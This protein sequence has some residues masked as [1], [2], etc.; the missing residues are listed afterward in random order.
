MENFMQSNKKIWVDLGCG[1][2]KPE[3]YIG[4]DIRKFKGVDHVLDLG[5][6]PMPFGD[7]FVD[8]LRALHLFE[9]FYP[10]ELFYCIEECWR[11]LKPKGRIHIEVPKA[12]TMAYYMHPDHKIQFVENTFSFFQ[13]PAGGIDPHGY[14]KHFWHVSVLESPHDEHVLVDMYPN[15]P[16]GRFDYKEIVVD[17]VV[18]SS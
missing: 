15:K 2:R 6:E 10:H 12:G 9:H 16:N 1:K 3:G 14:L 11:V 18:E 13:V 17:K 8:V 5:K 4:I 7:N